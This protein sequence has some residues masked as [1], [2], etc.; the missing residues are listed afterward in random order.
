LHDHEQLPAPE[1]HRELCKTCG[2][3]LGI[4]CPAILE[5]EGG[6]VQIDE[7]VC[8]GCDLCVEVCPYGAL[9]SR[10]KEAADA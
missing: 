3:C 8:T 10:A 7:S 9:T 1:Y 2:L 6:Y 4:D 5:L